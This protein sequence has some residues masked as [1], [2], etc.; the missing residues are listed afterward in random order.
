MTHK[1]DAAKSHLLAN[2]EAR[3]AANELRFDDLRDATTFQ[4]VFNDSENS[5]VAAMTEKLLEGVKS[6]SKRRAKAPASSSAPAK[7]H[8]TQVKDD[9]DGFNDLFG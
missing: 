5:H 2:L 4:F 6:G 8:K 7:K 3:M 1:G 9:G